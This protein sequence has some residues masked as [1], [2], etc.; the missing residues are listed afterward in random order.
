MSQ[1]A[2]VGDMLA[3]HAQLFP[4]KIGAGDLERTILGGRGGISRY[5]PTEGVPSTRALAL[6]R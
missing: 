4:D 1:L 2:H 6:E 5:N 3:L